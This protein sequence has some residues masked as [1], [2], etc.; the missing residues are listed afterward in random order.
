MQTAVR[1]AG[2]KWK[3]KDIYQIDKCSSGFMFIRIDRRNIGC[4]T[5]DDCREHT[6]HTHSTVTKSFIV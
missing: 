5:F 6:P 2:K 1:K 4:P 3:T